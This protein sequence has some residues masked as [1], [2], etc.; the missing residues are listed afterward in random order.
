MPRWPRTFRE[1]PRPAA[2]N[3]EMKTPSIVQQNFVP[4]PVPLDDLPPPIRE[5]VR[6][7]LEHPTL[8]LAGPAGSFRCR[9]VLYYWLLDHPDWRRIYGESLGAKCTDIQAQGEGNFFWKDPRMGRCIGTRWLV[10]PCSRRVWYA[11][12][13][14]KAGTYASVRDGPRR[15]GPQPS[16]RHRWQRQT[17]GT[18]S[19]GPCILHTDSRAVNL[20]TRLLGGPAPRMAEEYVGQLDVFG[21]L[22]LVSDRASRTRR[23]RCSRALKQPSGNGVTGRRQSHAEDTAVSFV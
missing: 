19:D 9:P 21:A 18:P 1:E 10:R 7:V 22:G 20:A 4:E 16:G 3:E 17:R 6:T 14:V 11:E 12:G 2:A 15:G 5:S 8:V 23:R 13:R